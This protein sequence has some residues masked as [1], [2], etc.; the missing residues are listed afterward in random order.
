[1]AK[2]SDTDAAAPAAETPA[3]D[4]AA[5]AAS[6]PVKWSPGDALSANIDLRAMTAAMFPGQEIVKV[7]AHGRDPENADR[8]L[9]ESF[10]PEGEIQAVYGLPFRV[11]KY[12][13]VKDQEGNETGVIRGGTA[14]LT[15]YVPRSMF[16][17]ARYEEIADDQA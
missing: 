15:G 1:M 16:T 4:A 7:K 11:G 12:S 2:K 6:F 13:R 10:M 9:A 3:T 8:I 17:S 5:P 14:S